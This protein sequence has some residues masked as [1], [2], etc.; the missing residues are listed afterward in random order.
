M[1]GELQDWVLFIGRFHSLVVHFPIGI[2]LS[3][4]LIE[5]FSLVRRSTDLD[6]AIVFLLEMSGYFSL[7]AV[8]VGFCLAQE[9]GYNEERLALH[10]WMGVL[11]T[12]AIFATLFIKRRY[13]RYKEA[14]W[15]WSYR[16]MLLL[17]SIILVVGAHQGGV[18]AHGQ[19]YLTEHFP[20]KFDQSTSS[21]SYEKEGLIDPVKKNAHEALPTISYK[22]EVHPIL[23]AKC[24]DCHGPDKSKVGLRLDSAAFIKKGSKLGPVIIPGDPFKSLV[25][26][27]AAL[28]RDHEDLMPPKGDPLTARELNILKTWIEQGASFDVGDVKWDVVSKPP[29]RAPQPGDAFKWSNEQQAVIHEIEEKGVIVRLLQGESQRIEIDFSHAELAEDQIALNFLEPL[30]DN[31]ETLDF[32]K[33]NITDKQLMQID[34]FKNLR[35]L[36]L[37]KTEVTDTGISYLVKS[38]NLEYLNLHSTSITHA[39]LASIKHLKK[40]KNLYLWQT[41]ISESH[42]RE[43]K[44]AL[45]VTKIIH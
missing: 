37:E 18:M 24:V 39:S 30:K 28:P 44:K 34:G 21:Q 14:S 4:L 19:N 27:L 43:L 11:L 33:T 3:V 23:F 10:Q 8:G 36:H 12:V 1:F 41:D 17:S 25:Y 31:V 16:G 42:V 35:V 38:V 32:S 6:T 9:G 2:L 20:L 40:L 7:L 26:T 13:H 29:D 22:N 45:P 5:C 15:G